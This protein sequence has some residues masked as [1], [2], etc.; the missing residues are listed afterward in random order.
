MSWRGIVKE[1]V[2]RPVR[3]TPI[4]KRREKKKSAELR[5]LQVILKIVMVPDG[6]LGREARSVAGGGLHRALATGAGVRNRTA[7]SVVE[8]TRSR[9]AAHS[10]HRLCVLGAVR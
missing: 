5:N 9:L 4:S 7:S 6:E 8:E 10:L 3:A 1:I 2:A